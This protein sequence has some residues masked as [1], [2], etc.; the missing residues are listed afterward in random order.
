VATEIERKFLVVGEH[1]RDQ[2][3]RSERYRQGYLAVNEH[4]GVRVRMAG[5]SATL[6]VKSAGLDIC[7]QEFEYAIPPG[8]ARAMLDQLCGGM[9]LSKTRYIIRHAGH[10]W[11]VDEF[12][13]ANAGLVLAEIELRTA[14]EQFARP[15]WLGEEVS[16]DARYLNSN[17]VRNPYRQWR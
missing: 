7:R 4:C 9:E 16:G 3:S 1:W 10:T 6:N 15:D 12:D 2:A 13:G 8:D 17:L 14:D 11:E 5:K